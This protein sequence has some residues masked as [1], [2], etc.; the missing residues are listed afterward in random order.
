MGKLR[1]VIAHQEI[2]WDLEVQLLEL[3]R[4]DRTG[5][6]KLAMQSEGIRNMILSAVL[7]AK[8][9]IL[10]DSLQS[11]SDDRHGQDAW[12]LRGPDVTGTIPLEACEIKTC[13]HL[14]PGEK[15]SS[16]FEYHDESVKGYERLIGEHQLCGTYRPC[17][18]GL[19]RIVEVYVLYVGSVLHE[20]WKLRLEQLKANPD[21][22]RKRIGYSLATLKKMGA[23]KL[24]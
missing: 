16:K 22:K 5:F 12:L 14:E 13:Y 23:I 6:S 2:P 21:E 4:K 3:V 8:D 18:D 10:P 24:V 7:E 15:S 9:A 20:H 17:P 1:P 19:E 11:A